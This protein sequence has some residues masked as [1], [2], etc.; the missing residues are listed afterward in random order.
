MIPRKT[1]YILAGS[2]SLLAGCFIY[3]G[4]R[5]NTYIA[6]LATLC[7]DLKP[8]QAWL[9]PYAGNFLMFQLPDF[10]WGLSLGCFLQALHMPN[11]LGS[12]YC[13]VT[14]FACG[15]A[16]ELL[17][18]LHFI[19]GTADFLDILMYLSASILTAITNIK[20]RNV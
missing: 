12:L 10:L 3:I 17:Q 16:W 19:P 2:L 13:G 5:S 7:V 6:K 11:G 8:L 18:L 20:E 15:T 4:F 9:R 14:V 1:A